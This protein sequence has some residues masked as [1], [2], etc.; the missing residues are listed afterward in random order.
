MESITRHVGVEHVEAAQPPTVEDGF[1]DVVFR[2]FY[3]RYV[4]VPPLVVRGYGILVGGGRI[5]QVAVESGFVFAG[6]VG[7]LVGN[8]T[9]LQLGGPLFTGL[10]AYGRHEFA[11]FGGEAIA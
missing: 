7:Q 4:L 10:D 1:V 2:C 11:V 5:D 3:V 6:G 8:Q 9:Q